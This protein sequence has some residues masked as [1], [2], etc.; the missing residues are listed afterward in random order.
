[1]ETLRK[2]VLNKAGFYYSLART[3]NFAMQGL[4]LPWVTAL[5]TGARREPPKE[6]K[7]HITEALLK[8]KDLH[9]KD[10]E[11]IKNGLYPADVLY[12]ESLLKH[13]L[14]YPQVLLD[15]FRASKRR[16]KKEAHE[17]SDE[18][19]EI[20]ADLPD[21]YKRNFHFQTGGYLST[22]SA[23]LYEHQVGVGFSEGS[24]HLR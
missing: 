1:M 7:T 4:L 24:N 10:F 5:A 2:K 21:Y 15:A 16:E 9:E 19:K 11:N 6:F 22:I 18:A 8:I 17:F 3:G 13:A 20:L 23:E 14:R 12:P